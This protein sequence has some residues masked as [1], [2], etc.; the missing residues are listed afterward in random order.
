M[1]KPVRYRWRSFPD[2]LMHAPE[3]SVKRHGAYV[4][5]KTGDMAAAVELVLDALSVPV[6]ENL[7]RAFDTRQPALASVHAEEA[8][9]TNAIGEA[10][11]TIIAT[12]LNWAYEREIIQINKVSHTGASGFARLR[13]QALF[14]GR[15]RSGLHYVLVDDFIGQG[16]TLA[17][18]RGHLMGQGAVV[19]GASV[20][21]GK[22]YS[23]RLTPL[24]QQIDELRRKHGDI[25]HWWYRRFGFNFDCLIASEARYL[26]RTPTSERIIAQLEAA[27]G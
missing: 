25:E 10:M 16:G 21:T 11:A 19:I 7:W 18:L 1:D 26:C 24:P 17:N 2:V 15:A 20:L 5:A 14:S 13:G 3:L 23:A 12:K 27:D 6:L 9:G 4:A 22:N 8:Q